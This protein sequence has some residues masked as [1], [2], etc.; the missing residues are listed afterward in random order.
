[1]NAHEGVL[2]INEVLMGNL[3]AGLTD[4]EIVVS[5]GLT[6]CMAVG[7]S[8]LWSAYLAES[9]ER[10]RELLELGRRTLTDLNN[11]GIGKASRV[12]AIT[13][14]LIDGLS[15]FLAALVVLTPS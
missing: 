15:P 1:V 3:T 2:P 14:S 10:K 5:T 7:V 12:A 13:A 11:T 8:G 6:T 4:P 9:A